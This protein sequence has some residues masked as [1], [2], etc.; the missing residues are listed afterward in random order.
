LRA[1]WE[2]IAFA[3]VNGARNNLNTANIGIGLR[4]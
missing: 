4:F 3:S 1:E 2:F